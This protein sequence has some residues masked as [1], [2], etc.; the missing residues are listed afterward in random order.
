MFKKSYIP[1]NYNLIVNTISINYNTCIVHLIIYSI[2]I[3]ILK[4]L[5]ASLSKHI[6]I[7]YVRYYNLIFGYIYKFETMY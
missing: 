6:N 4:D 7:T 5:I 1:Y 2:S 3:I